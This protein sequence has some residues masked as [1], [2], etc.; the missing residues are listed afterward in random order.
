VKALGT[1]VAQAFAS[2]ANR[3]PQR[4]ALFH[5]TDDDVLCMRSSA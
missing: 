3:H 4:A 5:A 2:G 1:L